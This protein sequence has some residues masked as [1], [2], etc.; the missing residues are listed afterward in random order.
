M[1]VRHPANFTTFK[2]CDAVEASD[3][4]DPNDGRFP[5][6]LGQ[7][8]FNEPFDY[9]Y[10]QW[11]LTDGWRAF[12]IEKWFGIWASD[13][14]WEASAKQLARLYGEWPSKDRTPL[15]RAFHWLVDS[16]CERADGST[17]WKLVN[18]LVSDIGIG[19]PPNP[20]PDDEDTRLRQAH[21]VPTALGRKNISKSLRFRVFKRDGF[22]CQYCGQR[23]PNVTLHC[24]HVKPVAA[25]GKSDFGNLIT[26]C[27]DCNLGKGASRGVDERIA[28]LKK[29]A[30]IAKPFSGDAEK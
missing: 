2:E 13:S 1:I 11:L 23:A 27:I 8:L 26:A 3:S 22:T 17:A 21:G 19:F 15:H 16:A 10:I 6:D 14:V 9:D 7:P 20:D 29:I 12:R 24:D 25:G 28:E 30:G 18:K 5:P 4:Y